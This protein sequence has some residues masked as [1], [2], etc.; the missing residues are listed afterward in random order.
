MV[1]KQR[2]LPTADNFFFLN[3]FHQHIKA[4][5]K[6]GKQKFKARYPGSRGDF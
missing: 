5:K 1:I 3:M 2:W 4:L 6:Y